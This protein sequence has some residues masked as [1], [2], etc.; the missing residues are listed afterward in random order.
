[1]IFSLSP[2]ILLLNIL[3]YKL[4]VYVVINVYFVYKTTKC[5]RRSS[6]SIIS[7]S[8]IY[9]QQQQHQQMQTTTTANHA[10]LFGVKLIKIVLFGAIL[11]CLLV[12]RRSSVDSDNVHCTKKNTTTTTPT[13]SSNNVLVDAQ[14]FI[15]IIIGWCISI[16]NIIDHMLVMTYEHN[17]SNQIIITKANYVGRFL[18]YSLYNVLGKEQVYILVVMLEGIEIINLCH[19]CYT[20][21]INRMNRHVTILLSNKVL[22]TSMSLASTTITTTSLSQTTQQTLIMNVSYCI[23]TI[24]FWGSLII[25]TIFN[26]QNVFLIIFSLGEFVGSILATLFVVTT[27]ITWKWLVCVESARL[28]LIALVTTTTMSLPQPLTT[29]LIVTSI[30]VLA[31]ISGIQQ[32]DKLKEPNRF[33]NIGKILGLVVLN[34]LFYLPM[35]LSSDMFK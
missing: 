28:V 30:L 1:M 14:L 19:T 34:V 9:R 12:Y 29:M 17:Y 16:C 4:S 35:S 27:N 11:V 13:D 31:I 10:L 3:I 2:L 15:T 24:I 33:I 25:A 8:S 7:S 26:V 20:K 18:I 22:D 32:N 21:P 23:N 6:S 5:G